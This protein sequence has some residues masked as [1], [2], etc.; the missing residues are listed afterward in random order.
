MN[1]HIVSVGIPRRLGRLTLV[2][3]VQRRTG[4]L[5]VIDPS[6]RDDPRRRVSLGN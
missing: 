1:N 3:D 5:D 2:L 4:L 6:P